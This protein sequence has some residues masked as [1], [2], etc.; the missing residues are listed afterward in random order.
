[1]G[2]KKYVPAW[3][4]EIEAKVSAIR[5]QLKVLYDLE[6]TDWH[7][8]IFASQAKD[9]K[10]W[11]SAKSPKTAPDGNP[12]K[13]LF[14]EE[15]DLLSRL[16]K[17]YAQMDEME[18]G[19][20]DRDRS[21]PPD[22]PFYTSTF[23]SFIKSIKLRLKTNE[24]HRD[25]YLERQGRFARQ[26]DSAKRFARAAL[27]S[28]KGIY[29]FDNRPKG[30]GPISTAITAKQ[31]VFVMYKTLCEIDKRFA[32]AGR[33]ATCAK[34]IYEILVAAGV[35]RDYSLNT[36]GRGIAQDIIRTSIYEIQRQTDRIKFKKHK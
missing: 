35:H 33:Q 11:K 29:R 5:P 30:R 2:K 9:Y 12:V 23:A 28:L 17:L 34:I 3:F 32:A 4:G 21:T 31:V 26:D 16:L 25:G 7:I 19:E 15:H 13:T 22:K 10:R 27:F 8:H 36:K 14:A 24:L 6:L 1:M 18:Q 20:R